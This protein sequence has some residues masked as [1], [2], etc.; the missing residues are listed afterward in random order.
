MIFPT[1][2]IPE[3]GSNRLPVRGKKAPVFTGDAAGASSREAE[4]YP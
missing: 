1:A 2:D 4:V 3:I